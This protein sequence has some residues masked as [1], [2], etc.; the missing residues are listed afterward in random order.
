M[1]YRRWTADAPQWS[2]YHISGACSISASSVGYR[3]TMIL[4][5]WPLLHAVWR[6]SAA[7]SVV[8]VPEVHSGAD[9]DTPSRVRN[10]KSTLPL[11][12][13]TKKVSYQCMRCLYHYTRHSVRTSMFPNAVSQAQ[14][15][16]P[17]FSQ[18]WRRSGGTDTCHKAVLLSL[19]LR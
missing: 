9:V 11:P 18:G 8:L 12:A 6:P 7:A 17:E 16:C 2:L 4:F 13:R 1:R 14:A 5:C 15:S 3:L 10:Q 19:L